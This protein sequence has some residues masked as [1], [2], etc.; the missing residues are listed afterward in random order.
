MLKRVAFLDSAGKVT[1]MEKSVVYVVRRHDAEVGFVE[2]F[3]LTD[4]LRNPRRA[5]GVLE[6]AVIVVPG[7]EKELDHFGKKKPRRLGPPEPEFVFK[8]ANGKAIGRAKSAEELAA[9]IRIAPLSAVLQH[10]NK[11][12]FSMGLMKMGRQSLARHVGKI[13]G[14]NEHVRRALLEALA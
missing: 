12:E 6:N 11:G 2:S 8:M 1:T 7:D 10:A 13:K 5:D 4:V 3:G 14:A 9:F